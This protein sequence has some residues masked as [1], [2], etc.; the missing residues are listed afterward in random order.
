MIKIYGPKA[1]SAW[2]T[3]WTAEECG[4][5]Y[6]N[7]NVKMREGEHKTPEFLK[8][9]PNGKVP[10]MV[11]GDLVM[12]ESMAINT[13]LAEKYKAE[14]LGKTVEEH[15]LVYQWSYWAIAHMAHA[16]TT[17]IGPKYGRIVS[18]ENLSEARSQVTK[19]LDILEAHLQGKNYMV[20]EGFT[21]ADINI[22]T[23]VGMAP[24]VNVDLSSYVNVQKWMALQ[25]QRPA[26]IKTM[27]EA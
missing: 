8:L 15:G 2:R 1:S 9:N 4:V 24:Q 23:V 12:F 20:G 14:L 13:Y 10:V 22:I 17:L 27:P 18:E 21:I 19:Y 5:A 26:F 7:I 11:D 3:I 25:M 6:E 16:F